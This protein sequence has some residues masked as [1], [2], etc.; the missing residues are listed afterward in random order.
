[1]GIFVNCDVF[2]TQN[3]VK[4]SLSSRKL[5]F[6]GFY[7]NICPIWA[8]SGNFAEKLSMSFVFCSMLHVYLLLNSEA[9]REVT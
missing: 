1:M 7:K 5:D 6:N 8:E 3:G 2:Y 9:V 4:P